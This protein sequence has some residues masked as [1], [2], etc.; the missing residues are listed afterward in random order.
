MENMT[1]DFLRFESKVWNETCVYLRMY[2][3]AELEGYYHKFS[4]FKLISTVTIQSFR[5]EITQNFI[6]EK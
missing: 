3:L 5:S 4:P 6:K 2:F 1:H